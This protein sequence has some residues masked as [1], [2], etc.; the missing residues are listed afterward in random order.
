[1]LHVAD[2]TPPRQLSDREIDTKVPHSARIWN[3]WLGGIDN[4][5]IDRQVGEQ[6]AY[7]GA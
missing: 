1:M 4:F 5:A 3:Y 2:E 7:S 6:E